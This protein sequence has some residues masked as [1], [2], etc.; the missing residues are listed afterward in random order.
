MNKIVLGM[1]IISFLCV[2]LVYALVEIPQGFANAKDSN[3]LKQ[4][5]KNKSLLLNFTNFETSY[6]GKK[7]FIGNLMIFLRQ[8]SILF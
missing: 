6:L 2:S 1:F 7:K 8:R 4:A 3:L 5:W